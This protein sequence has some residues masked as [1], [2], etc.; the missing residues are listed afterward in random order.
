MEK[1]L[2]MKQLKI[3]AEPNR[4]AILDL[5]M[6]GTHCNCE[7]VK[8]LQMPPN[9]ISHHLGVLKDAGLVVVRRDEKDARWIYYS[10]NSEALQVLRSGLFSFLD[11]SRIKERIPAC[12]PELKIQPSK[13]CGAGKN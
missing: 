10:V 12:K 8:K 11:V 6:E 4:F 7:F 3:L 13:G 1:E 5:L 2:L 9:L